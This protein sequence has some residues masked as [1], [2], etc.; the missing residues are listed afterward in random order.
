LSL[1]SGVFNKCTAEGTVVV[2]AVVEAT[3]AVGLFGIVVL[4]AVAEVEMVEL[5]SL[6]VIG[7]EPGRT[8]K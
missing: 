7:R 6:P 1:R 3:L 2:P 5:V 4:L 8:N